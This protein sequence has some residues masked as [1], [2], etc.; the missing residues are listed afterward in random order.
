M[1]ARMTSTRDEPP[2]LAGMRAVAEA[3]ARCLGGGAHAQMR[4]GVAQ[5]VFLRGALELRPEGDR[6]RVS[7]VGDGQIVGSVGGAEL[8]AADRA[9]IFEA[10]ERA[11]ARLSFESMVLGQPLRVIRELGTLKVGMRVRWV[12]Y[13]DVDNHFGRQRFEA[14]DRRH[15]IEGDFSSAANPCTW[16]FLYLEKVGG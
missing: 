8:D 4:A 2:D 1:L 9:V 11:Q 15:V 3:V 13:D 12:G 16:A 10:Q 5:V 7:L 6:V 14:D